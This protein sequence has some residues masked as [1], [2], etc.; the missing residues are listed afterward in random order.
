MTP[1]PRR[2]APWIIAGLV[3]LLCMVAL[4]G[5]HQVATWMKKGAS[6][7]LTGAAALSPSAP[8]SVT[9]RVEVPLDARRR[10]LIGV[11]TTTV[12]RRSMTSTIRAVGVVKADETRLTDVNVKID[13]WIRELKV[14][15]TGQNV[16][17]AAP[18]FSLYSPDLLATEREYVLAVKG[19]NELR[20][21]VVPD[22]RART[23]SLAA[24]A[25]QRLQLWDLPADE[26]ARLEQSLEAHDTVTFRSPADGVVLEKVA[27]AGMH[28]TAGQT[29]YRLG[30]LGVVWIEADAYEHDLPAIRVGASARVTLD[31]YPTA[32]LTARVVFISP[33]L[34]P[35]TRTAKVRFTVSNPDGRLKPGMYASVE[36]ATSSNAALIV[37]IDAVLDSGREQL[38]FVANG[39]GTFVPRHVQVGARWPD[40]AEILSGVKDGD[41]VATSAAFFLDSESQLRAGVDAY[42]EAA[43]P[44][45]PQAPSASPLVIALNAPSDPA[46][47]GENTFEV[48]VQDQSSR[49]IADAD[50]TVQLFMPAMPTMSMPA[51]RNTVKTTT[52]GNGVYRGSGEIMMAGRWEVTITVMRNGQRLGSQQST[53]VAR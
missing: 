51:M 50:V 23:E 46:K 15:A 14:D 36:L 2:L 45:A 18:L 52:V 21:S 39:D 4:F 24:S 8:P 38:V 42:A 7:G 17:K 30:N 19:G 25:R 5:R 35:D 33:S 27:M 41:Q 11:R 26:I 13:G 22:A 1:S 10:Q 49:P 20:D 28:V 16:A 6:G 47:A 53:L 37:P 32:P 34:Q 40:A 12:T 29:L 44:S 3:A 31:A 9:P 43:A 48:V